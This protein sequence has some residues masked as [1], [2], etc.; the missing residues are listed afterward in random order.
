MW[1]YKNLKTMYSIALQAHYSATIQRITK[2]NK[3]LLKA[4]NSTW[5]NLT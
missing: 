1:E 3:I 5:Q 2:G 4:R